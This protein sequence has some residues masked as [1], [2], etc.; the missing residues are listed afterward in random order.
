MFLLCQTVEL[1]VIDNV[2]KGA[3]AACSSMLKPTLEKILQCQVS[4]GLTIIFK[5]MK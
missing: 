3:E 2:A 1:K 4:P 5:L